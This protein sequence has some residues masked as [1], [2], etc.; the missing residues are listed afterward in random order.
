MRGPGARGLPRGQRSPGR[1]P[2]G[3]GLGAVTLG[4]AEGRFHQ[5][6]VIP[7]DG[8]EVLALPQWMS[9][10]CYVKPSLSNHHTR[11]RGEFF[12]NLEV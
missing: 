9:A 5:D 2:Q 7:S 12:L 6:L 8:F 10:E 4:G 11:V 3:A 1:E